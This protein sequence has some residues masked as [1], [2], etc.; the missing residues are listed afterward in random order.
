MHKWYTGHPPKGGLY[1]VTARRSVGFSECRYVFVCHFDD[2]RGCWFEFGDYGKHKIEDNK[3]VAWTNLPK[4]YEG[5][6]SWS[7]DEE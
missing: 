4:V 6:C 5:D 7:D 2:I 3:I 1:I